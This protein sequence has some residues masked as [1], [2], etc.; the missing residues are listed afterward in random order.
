PCGHLRQRGRDV[1]TLHP[2]RRLEHFGCH[3]RT[4]RSQ[5]VAGFDKA[6]ELRCQPL[7]LSPGPLGLR[8]SEAA[9]GATLDDTR[10]AA[11]IIGRLRPIALIVVES[12]QTAERA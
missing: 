4:L 8:G 5:A 1:R 2:L 6:P 7:R 11:P 9:L 12:S 10:A 3:A